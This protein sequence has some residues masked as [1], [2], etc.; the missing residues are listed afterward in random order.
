MENNLL[1]KVVE[2]IKFPCYYNKE[3]QFILDQDDNSICD[4]RGLSWIHE[5][6]SDMNISAQMQD[7]LGEKICELIN[8]L[9]PNK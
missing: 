9:N 3:G 5:T 2:K 7:A 8:T 1:N 6:N 4:I